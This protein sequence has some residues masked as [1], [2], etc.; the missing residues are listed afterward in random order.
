MNATDAR[1]RE[2]TLTRIFDAPRDLVWRAWTDPAMIAA[3]WG[4]RMFTAP[5]CEVDLRVGGEIRI[6]MRAPD[7]NEHT[8]KGIFRELVRPEKIVFVNNA[9]GADG[10]QHLEGITTVIFGDDGGKTK[11]TLYTI[12]TGLT[13]M[14][15]MMLAGMTEGWTQ[16]IDRLGE[17]VERAK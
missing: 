17:F 10:T 1:K 16:T 2:L 14:S 3:W 13:E 11:L 8:M 12:A 4:P 7:G 6:V 9:Y 15:E 5:V